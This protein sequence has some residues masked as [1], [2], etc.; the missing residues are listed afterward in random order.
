MNLVVEPPLA[1]AVIVIV[2][3]QLMSARLLELILRQAGFSRVSIL[4][5]ARELA[6]RCGQLQPD[7]LLLDLHL[8]SGNGLDV[9]AEVRAGRFGCRPA[10]IVLTADGAPDTERRARQGGAA[11][12]LT[13][14]Y[15]RHEI[16]ARVCQVLKIRVLER[17]RA[18]SPES[19][20]ASDDRADVQMEAVRRLGQVAEYRDDAT[21][22]HIVR[23]SEMSAY[24]AL[25]MGMSAAEADVVRR[26][27]PLHDIGKI[28]IPDR[29]LLKAGELQPEELALIRNH[30]TAGARILAGSRSPVMQTAAAIALTHHERW[31]G[32]GYP[33][34]LRGED[35]PLVSRICAVCDVF[36]VLT[37]PRP[38]RPAWS[39]EEAL[40]E[41]VAQRGRYFDPTVVDR[42][43]DV[44]PQI[45]EIRQRVTDDAAA[46][47]PRGS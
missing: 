26:A 8:P 25:A 22:L 43:H 4:T 35:I 44:L 38:H 45:L 41:I 5:D 31:D 24:L 32:N 40:A 10:V 23:M 9:L 21:G 30:T 33:N 47:L 19:P 27:S 42:F 14:P 3:D 17:Q 2:E 39:V 1:N 18:G 20:S 16:V 11:D 12:F 46:P 36:D 37:T 28:T 15:D 13:K 6:D 29:V 34:G 7:L